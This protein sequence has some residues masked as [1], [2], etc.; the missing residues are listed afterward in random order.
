MTTTPVCHT[1]Q[2]YIDFIKKQPCFMQH[3]SEVLPAYIELSDLFAVPLSSELH[4]IFNSDK[5]AFF[6][7]ISPLITCGIYL[8][9]YFKTVLKKD[10]KKILLELLL[11][12][13]N[14][15]FNLDSF[16]LIYNSLPIT[17]CKEDPRKK[18]IYIL[19]DYLIKKGMDPYRLTIELINDYLTKDDK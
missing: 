12:Y 6:G 8:S 15:E 16:A 18:M 3:N 1:H 13:F 2:D 17:S 10:Y 14:S 5:S 11:K 7:G 9:K 4:P 19:Y